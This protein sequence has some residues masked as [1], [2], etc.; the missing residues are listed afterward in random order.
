MISGPSALGSALDSTLS[1][2]LSGTGTVTEQGRRTRQLATVLHLFLEGLR[3]RCPQGRTG[4]RHISLRGT[5]T[6]D[7]PSPSTLEATLP[8]HEL[9]KLP[10]ASLTS[11]PTAPVTL[12]QVQSGHRMTLVQ[13]HM[14]SSQYPA[15]GGS[16]R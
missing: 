15:P 2:D 5:Q 7:L 11:K 1:I 4:G 14:V 10:P 9:Q 6:T 8:L 16:V 3:Q 13:G 12:Q